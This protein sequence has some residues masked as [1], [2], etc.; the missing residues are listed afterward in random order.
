MKVLHGIPAAPGLVIGS[1]QVIRPAPPVDVTAQRTT[2]TT[3]ETARL[4]QAI[5]QAK[6]RLDALRSAARGPTSDMLEAQREMVDDPELKQEAG[7]LIAAGLAAEAAITRVAA[8]YAEQL[9]S[10]PDA[11]LAA[12]AEDVREAGRRIVAELRGTSLEVRLDRPAILVAQD[13]APAETVGLDPAHLQ[14][15]VTETR[16][17]WRSWCARPDRRGHNSRRR[18]RPRNGDHRTRR[19]EPQRGGDTPGLSTA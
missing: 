11:Y 13:L 19:G 8:D 9:A 18:W 3:V 15:V 14:A 4:E 7:A 1:A 12:R 6:T 17:G 5:G 2:D 16:R 10:L